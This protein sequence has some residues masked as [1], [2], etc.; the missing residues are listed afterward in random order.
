MIYTIQIKNKR[1]E[2]SNCA[3]DSGGGD[4]VDSSDNGSMSD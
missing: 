3:E 1:A 4:R 2:N